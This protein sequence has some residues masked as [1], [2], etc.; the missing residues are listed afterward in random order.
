MDYITREVQEEKAYTEQ[1]ADFIWPQT[2]KNVCLHTKVM[3]KFICF[4]G[5]KMKEN[6]HRQ[7]K[8]TNIVN[9]S[10]GN[11]ICK[12]AVTQQASTTTVST[13]VV[14]RMGIWEPKAKRCVKTFTD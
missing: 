1:R 12:P 4:P 5:I 14:L 2:T 3:N 11:F 9:K 8:I 6:G 13:T 10:H 7:C